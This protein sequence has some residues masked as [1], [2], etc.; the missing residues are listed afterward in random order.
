MLSGI[1]QADGKISGAKQVS[2]LIV[3]QIGSGSDGVEMGKS[4]IYYVSNDAISLPKMA[5][6]DVNQLRGPDRDTKERNAR[7]EFMPVI[8]RLHILLI[9]RRVVRYSMFCLQA[10]HPKALRAILSS[11]DV[12]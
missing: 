11:K 9:Q 6:I 10:R 1:A 5:V 4:W 7:E 12:V 3:L 2:L 8:Q